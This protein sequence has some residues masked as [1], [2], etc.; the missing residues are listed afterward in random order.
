V[1]DPGV[2][3]VKDSLLELKGIGEGSL[4]N[5]GIT[6]PQGCFMLDFD[7]KPYRAHSGREQIKQVHST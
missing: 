4:F 1:P 5:V 6:C 7:V 3:R 2:S